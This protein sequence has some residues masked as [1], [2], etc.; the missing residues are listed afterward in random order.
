MPCC[1]TCL[2]WH[3]SHLSVACGWEMQLLLPQ[4]CWGGQSWGWQRKPHGAVPGGCS[5]AEPRQNLIA[6]EKQMSTSG[7]VLK[8]F[9]LRLIAGFTK[10]WPEAFQRG[11]VIQQKSGRSSWHLP[12]HEKE[13]WESH[14]KESYRS[15]EKD[16]LKV[17]PRQVYCHNYFCISRLHSP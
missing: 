3:T 16:N 14:K 12:L 6:H 7:G 2:L 11:L 9:S 13:G 17:S 1:G 4:L 5:A 10:L 15:S 8:A